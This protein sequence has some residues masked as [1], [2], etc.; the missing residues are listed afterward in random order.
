M[1]TLPVGTVIQ[2]LFYRS[3]KN[4]KET[5]WLTFGNKIKIRTSL[6]PGQELHIYTATKPPVREGREA[7]SVWFYQ[8]MT[9]WSLLQREITLATELSFLLSLP[10]NRVYMQCMSCSLPYSRVYMQD[11][12]YSLPYSRVYM[13]DKSCSLPYSRVYMQDKSCSLPY[14]RVYMQDKSYSLPYSRIY[15]QDKSYSLPY[16]RV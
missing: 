9:G 13:Q 10:Y 8:D 15:M 14:R 12:S 6:Q 5:P 3:H 1:E 4:K 2:L 11:K 7:I 16:N